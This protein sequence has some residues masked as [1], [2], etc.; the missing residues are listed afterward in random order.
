M[1]VRRLAAAVACLL[2]VT[3]LQPAARGEKPKLK[4][5]I[6]TGGCC[7]DYPKQKV[8]ISEA[9]S[10]RVSIEWDVWHTAKAEELVEKYQ[11]PDWIKPYDIVVHNECWANVADPK[12]IDSVVAAHA[13]NGVPAIVIHCAMHTFRATQSD[14]WRKLLGVTSRRHEKGGRQLD[15]KNVAADHPIMQGFPRMWH[16]PN[17]ELY[18]VE[19]AWDG[20]VPLATAFGEDT[21]A[22]QMCIWANQYGK[23]RVFGTTLG[24]HNETMM[25]PEW[26]D[27]TARGLL[28]CVGKL[29]DDGTPAD[30]Y[31]GAG[32]GPLSFEKDAGKSPTPA[33]R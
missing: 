20:A 29:N 19:K 22:D 24:H 1:F 2:V 21:K 4:G 25:S 30:G 17:G 3:L 26:L 6:I 10:Q 13:D 23:A 18:V 32:V 5:L 9:M 33:V 12:L 7:H 11:Q 15:V 31:A 8:I 27:V 16:T 14:E 28:W